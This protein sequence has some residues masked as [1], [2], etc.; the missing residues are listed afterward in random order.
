MIVDIKFVARTNDVQAMKQPRR[1]WFTEL[2]NTSL[3]AEALTI[4]MPVPGDVISVH[5][6]CHRS[7]ATY[8]LRPEGVRRGWRTAYDEELED[9]HGYA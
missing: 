4:P 3:P 2:D 7:F 8:R 1:L 5:S 6:R 9:R